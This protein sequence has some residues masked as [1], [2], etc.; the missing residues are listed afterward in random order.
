MMSS[1]EAAHDVLHP[2]QQSS[3][4][5]WKQNLPDHAHHPQFMCTSLRI[6]DGERD[7]KRLQ[8][9]IEALK[10]QDKSNALV[11]DIFKDLASSTPKVWAQ[12]DLDIED[13]E[14]QIVDF[15]SRRQSHLKTE[16]V[17]LLVENVS[18]LVSPIF[19]SMTVLTRKFFIQA[20]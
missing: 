19:C 11:S 18:P 7:G 14:V 20:C 4:F 1:L 15:P 10:N 2:L 17:D 12:S 16:V 9:R 13:G 3:G 8:E 6:R 5:P